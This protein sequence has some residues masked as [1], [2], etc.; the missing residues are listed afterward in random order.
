MRDIVSEALREFV[1]PYAKA[2][3]VPLVQALGRFLAY[4]GLDMSP[5]VAEPIVTALTA[6]LVWFIPNVPYAK[7]K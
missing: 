3:V 5:E 6:F 7:K 1:L 4:F 2:W